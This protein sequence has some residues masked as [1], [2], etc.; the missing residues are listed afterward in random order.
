MRLSFGK[1]FILA[2]TTLILFFAAFQIYQI[3][4]SAQTTLAD[5]RARLKVKNRL[6]FEK[7]NLIPHSSDKIQ[8]LQN[9]RETR[10]LIKFKDSYFAA[11]GGGLAEFS[12]DGK[13]T[14]HFTVLDGLPESDLT[15]LTVFQ[16]KLYIGTRT[17]NLV[18]FDGEKFENYFWTD[19]KA[20][21]ITAFLETNG[22]LLIGT[23][24]GLI[25]FDGANFTEIKAEGKRFSAI[26]CLY[27]NGSKLYIGTFD[28][29]LWINENDLWKQFTTVENLPSN[30]VV[31][32]AVKDDK[33]FV[34][35]D[36]GLAI[37]EDKHFRVIENIPTLSSLTARNNQLFLTKDNGSIFTFETNVKELS[38]EKNLR[39][40]RLISIEEKL[41]LLSNKGISELN[42]AKLK[43]FSQFDVNS[44]TDNFI[45]ALTFDRNQNIWLGTFHDGIDIYTPEGKKLKH[46][47]SENIR[48][49]NFLRSDNET[50][51]A[52]TSSGLMNIK[53]NFSVENLTK[54]DGLPSD[55]I[56]HFS[57]EYIATAKGLACR[58]NG[59]IRVLTNVN[60]LP[61]NSVY[62]TLQT[63]KKLY[64]GTLGGLAEIENDRVIRTFKD[65]NSRL[66]T[67]W[68]TALTFVNERLFIGTYGGGIFELTPSGE[69]R[70]FEAEAGKFVVNPN[71]FFSDGTRL[72]AGTLD[73]VKTLNL[74]TQEWKTVT[75]ILPAENVMSIAGN[76]NYIYFGT[77]GGAARIEKTYFEKN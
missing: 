57:N 37:L 4:R 62:T 15:V 3:Y 58:E 12:E 31:G 41:F 8:I 46:L 76:E 32:I 7:K 72:F 59:K 66:T 71:A 1:I 53:N 18:V 49:I 29:G 26:N 60:G 33:L 34:A 28:N 63:G 25:E 56:I 40:V 17:K 50:I 75:D 74:K 6:P 61:S 5:E 27:K 11:T 42:G 20:S 19:R 16:N 44:P 23:F 21:A 30:R 45:S 9:F 13:I 55:S 52:A 70:S 65:S 2:T 47:E 48:E 54:K 39:R 35:T 77:T 73:G 68:I 38:D 69:I 14:K 36:F 67:N 24:G 51:S 10:D 64:A 43:N 22:Q